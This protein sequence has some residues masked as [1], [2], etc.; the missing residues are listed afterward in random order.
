[1]LRFAVSSVFVLLLGLGLILASVPD[2]MAAIPDHHSTAVD[3]CAEC[4]DGLHE[5]VSEGAVPDCHHMNS[6]VLAML[7]PVTSLFN[8]LIL[9]ARHAL[10]T[11]ET[12]PDHSPDHDLP[13]PRT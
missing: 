2:V 11:S 1:M 9:R 10:P 3:A 13:P 4:S 12:G 8:P 5:D 7:P 6:V